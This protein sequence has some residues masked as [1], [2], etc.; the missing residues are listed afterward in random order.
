[1]P[2]NTPPSPPFDQVSPSGSAAVPG[3][4]SRA[5]NVKEFTPAIP[6]HGRLDTPHLT[7]RD[8]KFERAFEGMLMIIIKGK[9]SGWNG[10]T[11]H[12]HKGI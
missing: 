5:M 7:P 6:R 12:D 8:D 4:P 9:V 11:V 1:M 10:G 3:R 2:V